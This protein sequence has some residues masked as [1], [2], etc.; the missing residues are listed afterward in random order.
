MWIQGTFCLLFM[1]S[2]YRDWSSFWF[3]TQ[4]FW[5]NSWYY[6]DCPDFLFIHFL[7]GGGGSSLFFREMTKLLNKITPEPLPCANWGGVKPLSHSREIFLLCWIRSI[8]RISYPVI[9]LSVC[10]SISSKHYLSH[11][12]HNGSNLWTE[13]EFVRIFREGPGLNFTPPLMWDLSEM[14]DGIPC[15][16]LMI[17]NERLW[18]FPSYNYCWLIFS[19]YNEKW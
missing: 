1:S 12:V 11:R 16:V 19:L 5:W 2:N 18:L 10:L 3:K 4:S 15:G 8:E 6:E 7:G 13:W 9:I 14:G 17:G